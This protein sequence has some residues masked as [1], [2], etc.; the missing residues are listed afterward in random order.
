MRYLVSFNY[1]TDKHITTSKTVETIEDAETAARQLAQAAYPN[2]KLWMSSN[3]DALGG[4][5]RSFYWA[6]YGPYH[7]WLGTARLQEVEN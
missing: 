3:G 4:W 6:D 5:Q 7:W 1:H 2:H